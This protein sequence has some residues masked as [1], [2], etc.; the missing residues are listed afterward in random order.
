MYEPRGAQ[1]EA[2]CALEDTRAEGAKKALIQAALSFRNARNSED[3]GFFNGDHKCTDKA[4]V[5][6]SV[7]TLGRQ[8]YLNETYFP[9]D[10]LADRRGPQMIA[11][12]ERAPRGKYAGWRT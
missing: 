7:A 8:N 9:S 3:Y 11:P 10:Y 2:L 12:S 1:I 6:A 5:F 4:V